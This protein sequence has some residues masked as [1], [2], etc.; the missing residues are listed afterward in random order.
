LRRWRRRRTLKVNTATL[1]ILA[2]VKA[3]LCVHKDE[4][5]HLKEELKIL[6]QQKLEVEKA[7]AAGQVAGQATAEK[8]AKKGWW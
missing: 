6:V 3:D 4:I 7:A 1:G 2:F 5:K 8:P